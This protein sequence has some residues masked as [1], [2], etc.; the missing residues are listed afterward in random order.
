MLRGPK[1]EKRRADA[2]GNAVM[3]AKVATGK[4]ENIHRVRQERRRKTLG[5]IASMPRRSGG[6][7]EAIR[8]PPTARRAA[9]GLQDTGQATPAPRR[10][11]GPAI[12]FMARRHCV[13][14]RTISATQLG[15]PKIQIC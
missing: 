2:S 9:A 4:I 5:E 6:S 14:V 10:P 7:V 12:P 11:R 15:K 3:I 1:D 13:P 8:G